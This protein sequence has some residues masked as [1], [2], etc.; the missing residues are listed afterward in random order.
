VALYISGPTEGSVTWWVDNLYVRRQTVAWAG[1]AVA[2]DPWGRDNAWM[3]FKHHINSESDGIMFPHRGKWL[4]IR[5]QALTDD[6]EIRKVFMR[7]KYS[8]LGRLVWNS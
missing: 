4:Q 6:A 5:G 2:N 8:E 1:R 7:P 3:E